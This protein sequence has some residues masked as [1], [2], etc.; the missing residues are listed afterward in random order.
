[1]ISTTGLEARLAGGRLNVSLAC[2]CATEPAR[3]RLIL[4]AT[5]CGPRSERR[6]LLRVMARLLLQARTETTWSVAWRGATKR[7]P[8]RDG[9][10]W[11]GRH[12]AP[13]VRG[14]WRPA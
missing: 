1:M 2:L 4:Q 11:R 13:R 5:L 10:R 6:M 9:A 8:R 3:R 14:A 12:G 7:G